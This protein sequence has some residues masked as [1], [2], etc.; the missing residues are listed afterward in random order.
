MNEA[1]RGERSLRDLFADLFRDL[2]GLVQKEIQLAKRELS[3]KASQLGIGIAAIA[4]GGLLAFCGLLVLLDALVLKL[5]DF[6][7]PALAALIVGGTVAAIGIFLMLRGKSNL[8]AGNLVPSRTAESL[9]RDTELV[10][11]RLS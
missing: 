2:A 5:S 8:S 1:P 9:R 7:S 11:D 4:A 3:E 10:R 6:V